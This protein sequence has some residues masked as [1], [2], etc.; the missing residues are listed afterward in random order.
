MNRKHVCITVSIVL[1]LV[2]SCASGLGFLAVRG[3]QRSLAGPAPIQYE[4]PNELASVAMPEMADSLAW[5]ADGAYVVAGGFSDVVCVDVAKVAVVATFKATGGVQALAFSPDGKWL[6]VANGRF[7]DA[8]AAPPEL[9]LYD[10]PAFAEKFRAKTNLGNGFIDIA[11]AA[12]SKS[13]C[14]IDDPEG[15]RN[16]K[17][18]VRR[19]VLPAFTEQPAIRAPQ[20]GNYKSL[21]MSPDGRT[22]AV[23]DEPGQVAPRWVRLFDLTSG[24]ERSSF[25]ANTPLD[26]LGFTANG[27]A[28]G[29]FDTQ[30]LSW[31]DAATGKPADPGPVRVANQPAGVSGERA[32]HPVSPDGST[33]AVGTAEYPKFIGQGLGEPKNKYG[34]FVHVIDNL[35]AKTWTWRVGDAGGVTDTPALAFSPDGTKLAGTVKQPSGGSIVIWSVPK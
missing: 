22:L 20:V 29:V 10:V 12:D 11:W 13:L 3:I 16:Q 28:V 35:T 18:V 9:I 32:H 8:G 14:A 24:A 33:S 19:W 31:W 34:A 2:L 30:H 21:A 26:R 15:P 4:V 5:S 27:S 23:G 7:K 25:Q 17:A 1:L 6:A